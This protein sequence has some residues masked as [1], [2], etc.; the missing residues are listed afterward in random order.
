MRL[1]DLIRA[2]YPDADWSDAPDVEVSGVREDSRLVQPG[3]LFIARPGTRAN[4]GTFIADAT[5]RG[6]A[7][8]VTQSADLIPPP[9]PR[10]IVDD[11]AEAASVLAHCFHG[12]PSTKMKVLAVTGTN[13]K[14]TVAYLARSLLASAGKKCGMIGTVE[15]DDGLGTRPAEMTTPPAPLVAEWMAAMVENGCDAC[16]VEA[17][18]HALHQ[19]R[20]AG[21][22][23]AAGAF[24]NLTGDHLDY[25][26]TMDDYAAAKAMLFGQLPADAVAVVNADDP[27]AGLMVA[28]CRARVVH[29]GIDAEAEWRATDI[30][31][32]ADGTRFTLVC[33]SGSTDVTM[34]LVG[35]HNVQNALCAAAMVGETFGLTVEQLAA[36]LADAPGAPG[37]LQRVEAGQPFAVFVDYAHTDDALANVLTALR[38]LTAGKLSVVFGCGGD[39]DRSKRPRMAAVAGRLADAVYVTSDNP[40][41]EN[42]EAILAEIVAGLPGPPRLVEADRRAAIRAAVADA[43]AGDV[44]LIAGKGHEDY[45]IVGATKQHFDDVEEAQ[46]AAATGAS[47]LE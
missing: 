24:T 7:A 19:K 37:R 30:E 13:G 15:V 43:D 42:P 41:T 3:D 34:K 35:R 33:P 2:G 4:G 12:G 44:V 8:V 18:S 29:F 31:A 28:P 27:A 10:V 25:H 20:L 1:H 6:A 47:P 38:P 39:R 46:H 21:V 26:K 23:F 9:L 36:G 11:A 32:S 45:Q 14:T 40:R 22:R 5:A 16:A 17:S